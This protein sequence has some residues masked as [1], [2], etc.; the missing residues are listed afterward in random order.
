LASYPEVDQSLVAEMKDAI[1]SGNF[2]IEM[3]KARVEL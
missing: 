1:D 2:D 3:L